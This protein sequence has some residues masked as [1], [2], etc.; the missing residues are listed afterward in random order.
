MGEEKL[1]WTS[2]TFI[3]AFVGFAAFLLNQFNINIASAE[4]SDAI[5]NVVTGGSFLFSAVFRHVASAKTKLL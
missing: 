2:K 4:I 5:Y 1:L 3:T